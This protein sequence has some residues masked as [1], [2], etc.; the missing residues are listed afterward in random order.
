MN[1]YRIIGLM[2]GTSMD[3]VDL[4]DVS[5]HQDEKGQWSYSILHADTFPYPEELRVWLETA[6]KTDAQD[7]LVLDQHIGDHFARCIQTFIDQHSIPKSE[8]DAIASHGHTVFH[9]PD[10]GFTYQIGSGARMAAILELPVIND[11]RSKDVI[12]GGQGAP[13]VPIGD[14]LLL[15]DQAEAFLNI[16]GFSNICFPQVPVIAFDIG[17]G[18]LPINQLVTE[19]FNKPFD[20][21]GEIAKSGNVDKAL[22]SAWNDLPF[23]R[24]SAPKSLGNEWLQEVFLPMI[25]GTLT[26]EDQIATATEHV[27]YQIGRTLEKYRPNRV[28]VTGGGAKNDFLLDRISSYCPNVKVILPSPLLLDYKEALIFAFLGALFLNGDTNTLP[29]VTGASCP[30]RAGVLHT[31]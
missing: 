27:A 26:P 22:M 8:L 5:F 12:Q 11:F 31:P 17:P 15:R 28:M 6:W 13:L 18:N 20:D 21:K 7:L 30:V 4:A 23:Y 2:S 25:P 29:S 19:H 14:Q 1:A 16:G 10:R 24:K 3:G 9:Q